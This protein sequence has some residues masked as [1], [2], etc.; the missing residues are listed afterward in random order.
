MIGVYR[1]GQEK[2]VS[3]YYPISKHPEFESFDVKL[4]KLLSKKTFIKDALMT[5]PRVSE[6]EIASQMI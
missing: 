4:D 1:I 3:I 6:N 2:D 5:F